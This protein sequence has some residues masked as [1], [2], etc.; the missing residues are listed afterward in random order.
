M[1]AYN[2]N[3]SFVSLG[4]SADLFAAFSASAAPIIS[5]LATTSLEE[6]CFSRIAG[7]YSRFLELA[8]SLVFFMAGAAWVDSFF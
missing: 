4:S 2:V 7:F 1:S 5:A 6:R 8:G 3:R